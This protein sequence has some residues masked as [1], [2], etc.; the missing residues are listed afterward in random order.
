MTRILLFGAGSI[1]IVCA[2]TLAKG[3][4]DITL[5]CRSNYEAVFSNGISINSAIF[6][7]VS[8]RL[9]TVNQVPKSVDRRDEEWDFIV[10]CSKAY[11]GIPQLIA[12]AVSPSTT[13][14]VLVQN[15]IGTEESY[16]SAFPG[17]PILTCG[18]YIPADQ[19]RPGHVEMGKMHHLEIGPYAGVEASKSLQV[20]ADLFE[21]SGGIAT[22]YDE[23][24]IQAR[25][26]FKVAFNVTW[27][28]LCTLSHLDDS[29]FI[30]S[31]EISMD[32]ADAVSAEILKI[33]AAEGHSGLDL[34]EFQEQF[35]MFR[36]PKK[37]KP[38]GIVPSMLVDLRRGKQMEVEA[39]L[40]NTLRLAR[41]AGVSTPRL[42]L[43][44]MLLTGLN[45]SL[46]IEGKESQLKSIAGT[47]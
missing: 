25:K 12:P 32:V 38:K 46:T 1:G 16:R 34:T 20:F 30:Q 15:G 10:V 47:N 18:V 36:D 39:I 5:V 21:A 7:Q 45:R 27:N 19:T 26:W 3:G 31:S 33:A 41:K 44:Y 4:A 23:K 35:G 29:N 14:I 17:N 22:C 42:E 37:L 24:G 11:A 28:S 8:M 6:G 13:T 40:G 2:Y 9:P 43:L